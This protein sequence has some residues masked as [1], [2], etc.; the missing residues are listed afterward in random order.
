MSIINNDNFDRDTKLD[1]APLNT[2]FTDVQSATNTGAPDFL[3]IDETNVRNSG[4][5]NPQIAA[6]S[7]INGRNGFQLYLMES[8]NCGSAGGTTIPHTDFTTVLPNTLD[9]NGGA[10]IDL[11]EG[12]II[13]A[14]WFTE[15]AKTWTN[16]AATDGAPVPAQLQ[17]RS[18]WVQWLEW[19]LDGAGYTEVPGQ[20]DFVTAAAGLPV[21]YIGDPVA[22]TN[23]T[24]FIHHASIIDD[25]SVAE[26]VAP[27][28][29]V[30]S[31]NYSFLLNDIGTQFRL[32][33]TGAWLHTI[34]AGEAGSKTLSFRFKVGGLVVP[35]YNS[36]ATANFVVIAA[37]P[38]TPAQSNNPQLIVYNSQLAIIIMRAK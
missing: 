15:T 29:A 5:D 4:I 14:Y 10:A 12:D 18:A 22:S 19:D 13:R 8:A 21:G 2:K 17:S 33:S 36:T 38:V 35:I 6:T 26:N 27:T 1:P 37:S 24:T 3:G 30:P 11:A 32:M 9:L 28:D 7:L 16:G 23:A 20:G 25:G 31:A 34:T